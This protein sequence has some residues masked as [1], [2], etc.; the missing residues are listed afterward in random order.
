MPENPYVEHMRARIGDLPLQA[1]E[2]RAVIRDAAGGILL[3][4]RGEG[5]R[6]PGGGLQP[7]DNPA[8]AL[9]RL[10]G[11]ETGLRVE[12]VRLLGV[13]S[14]PDGGNTA[15]LRLVFE[16][17]LTAGGEAAALAAVDPQT[18]SGSPD[19]FPELARALD[20]PGPAFFQPPAWTPPSDGIRANGISAYIRDLRARIG[21]DLVLMPGAAAVIVDDAGRVLLQR[22]GDNGQWGVLGGAIDP[23]ES[24]AD[25]VVREVWEE[26]G[27]LVRPERLVGVYGGPENII[28][29]PNDDRAA[30]ISFTFACRVLEGVPIPDGVESLE[31]RSFD[32]REALS[33]LPD[34]IRRRA[35]DALRPPG[36]TAFDR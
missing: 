21:H 8:A 34:R 7:G 18:A 6:A 2:V 5:W 36:S 17:H 3:D 4:P 35:T 9:V 12:P 28:Q 20:A 31:L 13:C 26:S 11:E 24:P 32:V 27:L 1:V 19:L 23:G 10:V 15:T 29:Y 22:R 14:G 16:C 25:A 33:I 30:I